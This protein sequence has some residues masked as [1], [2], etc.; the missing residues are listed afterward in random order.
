M[1]ADLDRE[2]PMSLIT[3]S[4]ASTAD[5]DN[6]IRSLD[7]EVVAL[8]QILVPQGFRAEMGKVDAPAIHYNLKGSGRISING[9]PYFPLTPHLLVIVPPLTP[10][11][12]EVDSDTKAIQTIGQDCFKSDPEQRML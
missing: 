4:R 9:G 8:T 11:S 1:L 2:R 12:I 5:L 6:L 3:P 7:I 10:F